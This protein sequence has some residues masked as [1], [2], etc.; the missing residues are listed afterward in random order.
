M[1]PV[2]QS[3]LDQLKALDASLAADF[4]PF[5]EKIM[6]G[7]YTDAEIKNATSFDTRRRGVTR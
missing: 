2:I 3:L 7:N 6:A 5:V 4:R 1:E